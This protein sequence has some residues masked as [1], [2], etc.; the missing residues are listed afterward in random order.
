MRCAARLLGLVLAALAAAL[1]VAPTAAAEPPFRLPGYLIDHA[2]VLT[3][4]A[5]TDVKY[6]LNKLYKERKIRLWVVYV[7]DFSGE[8]PKSWAQTT[9]KASDLGSSDAIL[10]VATD[11]RAYAFL[12]PPDITNVTS[13]E[14]DNLRRNDIEPALRDGNWSQAAIAAANGLNNAG[15]SGSKA[16]WTWLIVVV[17]VIVLALAALLALM[18]WRRRR[19]RAAEFAAARRVDPTDPE[20]V[21]IGT[22]R[23]AR[24]PVARWS[25]RWTTR[26]A[27]ARTNSALAVEEFGATRPNRSPGRSNNAQSRAGAS[28]QGAPDARRRGTGD[29]AAAPRPVD[30]G[31]RRPPPPPTGSSTPRRRRSTSCAI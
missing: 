8:D 31:G 28:L 30:P 26:C 25:S 29:A 21:G 5:R 4:P 15:A 12:V 20:R 22:D 3:D 13:S 2:Q 14:V 7:N 1:L 19:R 24:R 18:S 17:G 23:R 6:A 10:A 9:Y 11:D 27:P 16:S